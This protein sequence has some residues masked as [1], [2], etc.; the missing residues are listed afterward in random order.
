MLLSA[1]HSSLSPLLVFVMLEGLGL[2]VHL[3][4]QYTILFVDIEVG[5]L[6]V[7]ILSRCPGLHVVGSW[8]RY[9]QIVLFVFV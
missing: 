1:L 2:Q 7:S 4:Q 6:V 5:G 9:K 8:Y 3:Y